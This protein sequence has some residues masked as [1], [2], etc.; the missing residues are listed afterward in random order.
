MVKLGIM[1]VFFAGFCLFF[2]P[3]PFLS[4]LP[5]DDVPSAISRAISYILTFNL[6]SHP[7]RSHRAYVKQQTE[8]PFAVHTKYVLILYE[9]PHKSAP[10]HAHKMLIGARFFLETH[11]DKGNL[12]LEH[13]RR[14]AVLQRVY[15]PSTCKPNTCK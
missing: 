5:L 12:L 9:S 15:S 1:V 8:L 4:P 13:F 3:S 7:N 11:C 6:E 10:F 2:Q 14:C